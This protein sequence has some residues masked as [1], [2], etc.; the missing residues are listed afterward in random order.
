M[1]IKVRIHYNRNEMKWTVKTYKGCPR[2]ECVWVKNGWE[3]EVKR[4]SK[5]NP[6]GF[7]LTTDDN[8]VILTRTEAEK[9]KERAKGR[10][11]Y[12]KV[13]MCFNMQ[14]GEELIF[15]KEGAFII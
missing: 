14:R 3:T 11:T 1:G 12:D 8:I 10:L 2:Y 4:E 6:R 15:T 5:S 7:V 13:N 9:V